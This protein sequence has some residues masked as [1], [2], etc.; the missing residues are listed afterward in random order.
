MIADWLHAKA[1]FITIKEARVTINRAAYLR[2]QLANCDFEIFWTAPKQVKDAKS[3]AGV[4]LIVRKSFLGQFEYQKEL[5]N[6]RTSPRQLILAQGSSYF[7]QAQATAS[8]FGLDKR[9]GGA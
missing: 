3:K 2:N 5:R 7:A 8:A 1:D 9:T 6:V 4:L